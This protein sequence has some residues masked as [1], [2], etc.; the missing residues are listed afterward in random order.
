MRKVMRGLGMA[1][2]VAALLAG[3]PRPAAAILGI[4]GENFFLTGTFADGSTLGGFVYI[5][6]QAPTGDPNLDK[7]SGTVV[8]GD[9]TVTLPSPQS[10]TLEFFNFGFQGL[11]STNVYEVDISTSEVSSPSYSMTLYLPVSTLVGYNGGPIISDTYTAGQTTF[12]SGYDV[13]GDPHLTMGQLSP[14]SVPEP[15]SLL[16]ACLGGGVLGLGWVASRFRRRK[17][18]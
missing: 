11:V 5:D 17:A 6:N 4:P 9:V 13:S 15:S 3:M 10:S 7:Y 16:L 2:L 18:A 8:A 1:M 14:T 12:V